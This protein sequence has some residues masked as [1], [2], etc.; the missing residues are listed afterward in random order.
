MK[1][2]LLFVAGGLGTLLRYGLSSL[3]QRHAGLSFPWGTFA[4]NMLGC[5]LFGLLWSLFESRIAVS[6]ELRVV[7]LV[8]FLGGFTTFSSFAF[9]AA[10]LLRGGAWLA[11]AG[12][13]L[14]QNSV[15]ILLVFAGLALGRHD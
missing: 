5:F 2:V 12:H 14:G 9:E 4:V 8:G 15:G 13:V 7:I 10:G 3:V 6:R 11:A 1:I